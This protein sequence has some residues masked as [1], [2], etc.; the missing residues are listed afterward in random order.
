VTRRT[1][2][3]E[4]EN[5]RVLGPMLGTR[6]ALTRP[7]GEREWFIVD[8]YCRQKNWGSWGGGDYVAGRTTVPGDARAW[9][10]RSARARTCP[11]GPVPVSLR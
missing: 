1:S 2:D 3:W 8:S 7:A 4:A 10:I 9:P 5:D 6:G 11:G